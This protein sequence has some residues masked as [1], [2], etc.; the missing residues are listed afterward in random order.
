MRRMSILSLLLVMTIAITVALP[1][2][3]SSDQSRKDVNDYL[4]KNSSIKYNSATVTANDTYMKMVVSPAAPDF[5]MNYSLQLANIAIGT[6]KSTPNITAYDMVI[7]DRHG[8]E[9]VSMRCT[10]KMLEGLNY[11][12]DNKVTRESFLTLG[13]KILYSTLK[14]FV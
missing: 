6:N 14:I 3:V 12:Q 4:L 7:K 9:I 13:L 10:K 8:I 5:A 11:T 2:E 1:A